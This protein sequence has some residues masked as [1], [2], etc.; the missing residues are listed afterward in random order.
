M[1]APFGMRVSARIKRA[2]MTKDAKS[3]LVVAHTPSANLRRM[4]EA[5]INGANAPEF[6][7]VRSR[8]VAAF[9]AQP[10][11]VWQAQAVVL[12]T[13]ENL[14]YMSGALKDFFDRCYYPCLERT[15][16]L[17]YALCVR[18]GHDGAGTQLA[19]ERIVT[20]LRW[21]KVQPPL[22]CKGE[23]RESFLEECLDLGAHIAAGLDAG[24]Y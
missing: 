19:V 24:I 13:P 15:Q 23:W 2:V 14:G 21:R 5:I 20:G 22:V 8:I 18:A 4:G 17:P 6:A 7:S 16:G 10:E 3:L 12:M 9:D 11:D 1:P